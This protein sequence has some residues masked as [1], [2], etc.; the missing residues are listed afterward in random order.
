[1]LWVAQQK[2]DL[3][4]RLDGKKLNLRDSFVWSGLRGRRHEVGNSQKNTSW[5]ECVEESGRS[6]GR[7]T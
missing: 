4:I 5:G 1:M 7:Y 2:T 6:D 3:D